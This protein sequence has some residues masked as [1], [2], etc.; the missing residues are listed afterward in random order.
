MKKVLFLFIIIALTS[1]CNSSK[2]E[3]RIDESVKKIVK[4][5]EPKKEEIQLEPIISR[6]IKKEDS[7]ISP[8][9]IPEVSQKTVEILKESFDEI[10]PQIA[11]KTK[12]TKADDTAKKIDYKVIIKDPEIIIE[13]KT[14]IEK[15]PK[16]KKI[17]EIETPKIAP[18][19]N[20]K[21][22]T[23]FLKKHVKPNGDVNYSAINADESELK[24][25]LNQFVKKPPKKS[26]RKNEKLAYWI[27]AYNAFTIKLI[28]DNYPLK[29]IKDIEAPWDKK[30]IPIDGKLI[31]LN[32][33]EHEILRKMNE[34][35]IHFAINCASVSCPKLLNE[36]FEA[37]QLN[38]QL[39]KVTKSFINNSK[40]NSLTKGE[41]K[42]SKI[43]K[44]FKNDFEK[45]GTLIDLLN[46]YSD[47]TID[48]NAK[49]GYLDYDWNLN[50]Q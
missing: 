1:G 33:I 9:E 30:F 29:S 5:I 14:I 8:E 48:A 24:V 50:K 34:P 41:V 32:H 37:D 40:K 4:V 26:W 44:W 18:Y 38:N 42:I 2:K 20:N 45:N 23:D 11:K 6:V 35:R 28:V 27:N 22:W 10:E 17:E 16:P 39:T 13:S 43:F 15:A 19:F 47:I 21:P 36:A 31:S 7:I 25:Y 49:I 46:R 3:K 12:P